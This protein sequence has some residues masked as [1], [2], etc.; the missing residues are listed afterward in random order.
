MLKKSMAVSI[1]I[2]LNRGLPLYDI[3]KNRMVP[4]YGIRKNKG[5]P[6][7]D[8]Q[9][10]IAGTSSSY[11]IARHNGQTVAATPNPDTEHRTETSSTI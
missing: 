11:G 9:R 6:Y 10:K 4:Y 2:P 1:I 3:L 7:Y 8:K 5:L